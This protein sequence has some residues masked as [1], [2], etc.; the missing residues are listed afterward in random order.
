MTS[1]N[2]ATVFG[3]GQNF[4][5]TLSD[6]SI[7]SF[8][9][10]ATGTANLNAIAPPSWSGSAVGNT[11]FLGIPN[12][13]IL[14]TASGGT[15]TLTMSNILITSPTGSTSGQ[16]KVVIADAEST[17]NGES[18]TY[19]TNGGGWT[20]IDQVDPISGSTYPTTT[21]TGTVY[22]ETG[23]A[24]TVG[25]YIV[26]TQTPS[27]VTA[28]IVAGGLQGIMFA[29]QYATISTNK[30]ITGSRAN[31]ADQ[32]V[33]GVK[34]TATGVNV[35][36]ATS[37]GAGLGPF[38]AA[39]A[40]VSSSVPVTVFEQMAAGSVSALT[41]Y[42]TILNCTNGTAGSPTVLPSN[43]P[44]TS[45]AIASIAYGDAISCTFTNTP[46]PA[47]VAVTK[48][49]LGA[50]GGPFS[51]TQTNLASTPASISTSSIGVAAPASP[52]AIAVTALNTQAQLTETLNPA[53]TL[54]SASCTDSNSAVSGN[55]ASFG[56]LSGA[57][58]TIPAANVVSAAAITCNFNNTASSPTI[59]LQKALGGTGRVAA[60]DQ[61][62]LQATGTGAPAPT[63]T[64]GSGTAITNAALS[65]SATANSSY[66]LNETMAAGST[67]ALN[68]YIQS[69]S[70]TNSN[71]VGTNVSAIATIPINFTPVQG[72]SIS[73][74]ITN[75][76]VVTSLVFTKNPS[77]PGPVTLG[78]TI[79]YTYTVTNNG[80][81]AMSN[82]QVKDLHGTPAVQI[83]NGAGG[84][85]NES[86]VTVGTSA[87]TDTVPNDGIWT[88]LAPGAKVQFTYT[89]TVTQAEI[90]HG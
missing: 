50:K 3:A 49:T 78:Q 80:N 51:F 8:K 90:D 55:P 85:T 63:V 62:S 7:F 30:I 72:D 26:G 76:P 23:V 9:L 33:Y 28:K 74:T 35:A 47:S 57:T 87:S 41:R 84:V 10:A 16:F 53:F 4:S 14:Y 56:T 25:A 60:A 5:I 22:T 79:T 11:A 6:G 64:T 24:G 21:N 58:L 43:Q 20:V 88:S 83:A 29:V 44:V 1:Y 27:N 19:T 13:P 75:T 67:S 71:A 38:G 34:A 77:T 65:F 89:H 82:V 17:N 42:T 54:T 68:K 48:T 52:T 66:V 12:K 36:V 59:S 31:A 18:L 81:V 40:T 32:F 45:Y 73:C 15:T 39:V 46:K 61:F 86:I 37:T 70:C 69:V 2:N